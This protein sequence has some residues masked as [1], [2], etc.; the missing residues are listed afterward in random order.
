VTDLSHPIRVLVV[1]DDPMVATGLT[2]I[3]GSEPDLNVVG[4]CSDGDQVRDAVA[5]LNPDVVL[6]DVKMARTNGIAVAEQLSALPD[7]PN[8]LMMT[9][10]DDDGLVL[11]AIRAGAT[12]FLLKEEDPQRFI[13]AVRQVA[14]GEVTYSQRAARQL[15]DWVHDSGTAEV[16]RAAIQKLAMLTDREKD[17]AVALMSGAS[18]AELAAKFYVAETTVKSALSSIKTKWGI[19]NRTQLAVVV[20]QAG[21]V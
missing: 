15:T 20:A 14:D 6:C 9:A 17:F 4:R 10:L 8:V 12:G 21:V 1:D 19:R 5:S 3:L 13:E 16:R 7:G 18:D 11:E 2:T